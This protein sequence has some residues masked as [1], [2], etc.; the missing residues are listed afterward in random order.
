MEN[1]RVPSSVAA[2]LAA[3]NAHDLDAFL[4]TFATAGSVDDWGRI[5]TG[6]EQIRRWSDA[7]FIG[8]GVTLS[9]L[10]YQAVESGV[11][12]SAQVGGGG[13]NG[14]STFTF[15][16]GDGGIDRMTITG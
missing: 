11:A 5:F 8:V 12:V 1:D 7:E 10:S 2:A 9:E 16:V 13:F 14:P 15:A 4:D 6:R 3:A